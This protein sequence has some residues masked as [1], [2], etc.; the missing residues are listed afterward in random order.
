M[1]LFL[2]ELQG[3]WIY[4]DKRSM[5]L[6]THQNGLANQCFHPF[7]L[8]VMQSIQDLIHGDNGDV[9]GTGF[10]RLKKKETSTFAIDQY[11]CMGGGAGQFH[12]VGVH[13]VLNLK[14]VRHLIGVVFGVTR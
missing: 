2:Q 11:D 14:G 3:C 13:G 4:F 7:V 12:R 6:C 8:L 10:S 9:D 5:K 1:V